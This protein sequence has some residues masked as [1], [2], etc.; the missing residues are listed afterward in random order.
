MAIPTR[1]RSIR[2]RR[3]SFDLRRTTFGFALC[4]LILAGG[5]MALRAAWRGTG[6]PPVA[7]AL[8]AVLALAAAFVVLRRRRRAR[9]VAAAVTDAAYR[10]VDAGVAELDAAEAARAQARPEPPEPA[11]PVDHAEL[12]PYAFEEAVAELC[13]RD[14]CP[15]AEVV[16]GA[17]DLGADV[18]ATTPDGRRLVVQCKRYG[19]E[20][21]A[22]SQ[23]LQRFG[24]TCYAVH[25]ADI[26]LVVSTGG[27][28]EPAL[29]YAEQCAILC[30]GPEELAAWSEGGAPP[31][32]ET[33]AVP[34][35]GPAAGLS[36]P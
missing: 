16:G 7:A 28:T 20:N 36:G 23:D 3:A 31:P 17:G 2:E 32:W 19:P 24:G 30:Y 4:A 12:D 33:A 1:G 13:R 18:L 9:R 25:E 21:R 10:I 35:E 26:A 15:D 5:G 6:L 34:A 14:G 8:S 11:G 27:F 22:G 29:D